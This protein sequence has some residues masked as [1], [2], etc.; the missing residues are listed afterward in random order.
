[1]SWQSVPYFLIWAAVFALMM[2]FGCGAHVM[3][4]SHRHGHGSQDDDTRRLDMRATDP[5]CGMEIDPRTAKSA[6]HLD[7]PVYFCSSSCR[8]KFEA[9]PSKYA[10][11]TSNP[12]ETHHGAR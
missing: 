1:M 12:M 6:V 3:G 11:A 9:E 8:D 10:K 4:R 7:R 5:V 2:R